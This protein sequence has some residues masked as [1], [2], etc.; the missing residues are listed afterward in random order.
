MSRKVRT[1]A[2]VAATLFFAMFATELPLCIH[3]LCE[4]HHPE[5]DSHECPICQ[6]LLTLPHSITVEEQTTI[7]RAPLCEWSLV[8]HIKVTPAI[9]TFHILGPRAPPSTDLD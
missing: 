4:E 3:L 2:V 6:Q 5:H 9:S 7:N 1:T 8:F